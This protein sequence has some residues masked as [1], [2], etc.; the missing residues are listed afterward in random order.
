[1]EQ[2]G[3]RPPRMSAQPMPHDTSADAE[4]TA[5]AMGDPAAPLDPID[6][7]RTTDTHEAA[8]SYTKFH[9]LRTA[10]ATFIATW[11][12]AANAGTLLWVVLPII[13]AGA[14]LFAQEQRLY[15]N[16]LVILALGAMIL[17]SGLN[18]IRSVAHQVDTQ[19]PIGNLLQKSL[20][21]RVGAVLLAVGV[22]IALF[23]PRW[24]GPGNIGLGVLGI[25]LAA[26][27]LAILFTLG[28]VP[29]QELLPAVAL[30]PVL[31][32][33]ALSTQI[34]PVL[35]HGK[36][37]ISGSHALSQ[38]E[39]LLALALAGLIF[40]AMIAAGL[41][42][43]KPTTDLSTRALLGEGSMRALFVVGLLI[44][45]IGAIGAGLARGVPH[46]TVAVLLS[47]PM[48][49]L[50]LTTILRART[51][52]ALQVVFPQM[53]RTVLWFGI[54]LVGGLILGGAYLHLLTALHG[55][56]NTK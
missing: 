47:L 3:N 43:P 13:T 4:A 32:F 55:I 26:V 34:T 50:P 22:V 54:W 37:I 56:I 45:Y 39:W 1:M 20:P 40:A 19:L 24:I 2:D 12:R 29:G 41:A 30:G 51:S 14:F 49:V 15:P 10:P 27:Y 44:A 23:A 52:A 48:A 46:A 16:R 35:S 53:Q 17:L 28:A 6:F 8:A 11:A 33:L 31:F 38:S 42:H 7:F 9:A 21:A 5:L 25:A 36:Q 18:L